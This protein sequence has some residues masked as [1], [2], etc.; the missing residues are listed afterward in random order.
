MPRPAISS[1]T[2]TAAAGSPIA[3]DSN[4]F[5]ANILLS[6]RINAAISQTLSAGHESQLGVNSNFVALNYVRHT[7]TWNIINGVLLGDRALL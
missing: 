7:A 5:Y 2:S 3:S 1:S 6:H 4:D